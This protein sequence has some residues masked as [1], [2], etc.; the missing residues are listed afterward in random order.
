MSQRETGFQ[1]QWTEAYI[2]R[3][4]IFKGAAGEGHIGAFEGEDAASGTCA[5]STAA[6]CPSGRCGPALENQPRKCDLIKKQ[7]E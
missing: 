7:N 6:R 4:A 3:S 5:I 1:I 2:T